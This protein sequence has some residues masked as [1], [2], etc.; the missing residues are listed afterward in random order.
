MSILGFLG[1]LVKPATDL[2]DSLHTSDEEKGQIKAHLM[3][4][5]NAFASKLLEYESK[6][7]EAQSSIIKAEAQSDSWL[8]KSWRPIFAL[9]LVGFWAAGKVGWGTPATAD[10]ISLMKICLGGYIIGRS[11]EKVVK[12]AP[13]LLKNAKDMMS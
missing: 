9:T 3:Q 4:I 12:A 10:E 5:E 13:G 7:M 1:G 8:A 2:V 6:L 11:G